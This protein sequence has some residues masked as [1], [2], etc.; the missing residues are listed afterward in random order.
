[1]TDISRRKRLTVYARRIIAI[2]ALLPLVIAALAACGG[3][4]S[5]HTPPPA[6]I[7][8]ASDTIAPTAAPAEKAASPQPST[9]QPQ[10]TG[11]TNPT[12]VYPP[13]IGGTPSSET[14]LPYPAE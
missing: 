3:E 11:T 10:E 6:T 8:R 1:M 13:P 7:I 12:E 5:R 9:P 14:P 4:D 2:V